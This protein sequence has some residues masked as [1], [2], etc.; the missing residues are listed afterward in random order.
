MK[1]PDLIPVAPRVAFSGMGQARIEKI[2]LF[3]IYLLKAICWQSAGTAGPE[4]GQRMRSYI[5]N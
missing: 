1:S 4:D 3:I 2:Y 5:S